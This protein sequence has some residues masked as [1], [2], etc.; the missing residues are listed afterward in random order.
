[1][2][3]DWVASSLLQHGEGLYVLAFAHVHLLEL[4]LWLLHG[5]GILRLGL[6]HFELFHVEDRHLG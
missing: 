5:L 3:L 2:L 4:L 1:M 6:L